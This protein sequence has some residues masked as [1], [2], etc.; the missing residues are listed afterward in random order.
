MVR[1]RD[2]SVWVASNSG[3]FRYIQGAWIEN[4]IEEGLP[5]AAIRDIYEDARG[6]L[7]AATSHGVSQFH[8][9]ADPDPPQ[10]FSQIF[11]GPESSV[12]EGVSISLSF[13]GQ[14]KWKYTPRERLLYSYRLDVRDCRHFTRPVGCL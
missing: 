4:G 1:T 11:P 9:E 14:D 6:R 3:L 12:P 5:S 13:S 10:T 8:P 7:W 2:G